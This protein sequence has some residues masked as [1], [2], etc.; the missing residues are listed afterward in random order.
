MQE[1]AFAVKH[2]TL[3]LISL[4]AVMSRRQVTD[5]AAQPTLT[6][7]PDAWQPRGSAPTGDVADEILRAEG[8]AHRRDLA[9]LNKA[10][11]TK[12]P[13][14]E[15][16]QHERRNR[17]A[18]HIRHHT[19]EPHSFRCPAPKAKSRKPVRHSPSFAASIG[20]RFLLSSPDVVIRPRTPR[21]SRRIS[22]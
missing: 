9:L 17:Q 20:G 19:L 2:S 4:A 1:S 16:S 14:L 5:D 22:L 15:L 3:H 10:N 8:P 18:G 6:A 12:I 21:T 13:G 7:I 11:L